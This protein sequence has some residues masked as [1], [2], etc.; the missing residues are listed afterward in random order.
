MKSSIVLL[1]LSTASALSVKEGKP[2]RSQAR[3][4]LK[5]APEVSPSRAEPHDELTMPLLHAAQSGDAAE[6]KAL[7]HRGAECDGLS[8]NGL[9][10]LV[11]A[12]NFGQLE[13]AEALLDGG[14]AI[15]A[16]V[17]NG[18]TALHAAAGRG[19]AAMVEM[20]LAR[21]A[22]VH[23]TSDSEVT[24]LM[25]AAQGGHASLVALLLAH[26]ANVE[27]SVHDQAHRPKAAPNVH[28]QALVILNHANWSRTQRPRSRRHR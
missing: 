12:A 4:E 18:L 9:T 2:S 24:P 6:V 7:L 16:Q 28:Q 14:S 11:I 22:H 23:I 20:L 19:Q 1:F 25:Y 8:T 15:N 5:V 17:R 26:G 27:K 21:G 13:A 10:A 3:A